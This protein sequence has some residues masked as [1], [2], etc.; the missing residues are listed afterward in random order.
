M[1]INPHFSGILPDGKAVRNYR[2]FSREWNKLLKGLKELG[3]VPRAYG[4][5]IA[6]TY[7]GYYMVFSIEFVRML[8]NLNA[9][10]KDAQARLSETR[11]DMMLKNKRPRGGMHTQQT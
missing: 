6:V 7:N 4:P 3:L 8:L 9:E 2:R 11:T 5:G 10:L 1:R